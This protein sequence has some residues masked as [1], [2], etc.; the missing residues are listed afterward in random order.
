[1]RP[2]QSFRQTGNDLTVVLD[3]AILY[4][5]NDI[6]PE[7]EGELKKIPGIIDP[8]SGITDTPQ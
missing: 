2:G 1:M 8:M 4:L 5:P 7:F 3:G 6:E